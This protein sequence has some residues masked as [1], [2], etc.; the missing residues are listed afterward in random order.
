MKLLLFFF[1]ILSFVLAVCLASFQSGRTDCIMGDVLT[2]V[3]NN[4]QTQNKNLSIK[5]CSS[6]QEE[7]EE[8][9]LLL[10]LS[11]LDQVELWRLQWCL[12]HNL[13]LDFPA[14]PQHWLRSANASCTAKT[15]LFCYHPGGALKVLSAALDLMNGD[16]NV[17]QLHLHRTDT[18]KPREVIRS[19]PKPDPDFVKTQRRK[20]ICRIQWLDVILDHL[21][22]TGVLNTSNREAINIYAV[23]E[24]KNRTLVN[25]VLTKGGEAQEFFYEALSQSEPFLLLELEKAQ[26]MDKVCVA[27]CETLSFSAS[28]FM[29]LMCFLFVISQNSSEMSIIEH[30][31]DFLVT[32]ELSLFHWLV[33]DHM[34]IDS[35]SRKQLKSEEM[36]ILLK[37]V[38]TL[39][40]PPP[41]ILGSANCADSD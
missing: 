2:T 38:P 22:D 7:D 37:I 27:E 1:N 34:T 4:P 9:V 17:C 18:P 39:R 11:K 33:R 28:V 41:T 3:Q 5:A 8:D 40:T 6:H 29:T 15:M 31:M 36:N 13:L 25:L 35:T 16:D 14:I 23:Q 26:I 10:K 32:D 21:Q 20:L 19:A 30:M 24:E 12:C